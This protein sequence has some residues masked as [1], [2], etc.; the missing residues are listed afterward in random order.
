MRRV[1]AIVLLTGLLLIGPAL[2]SS[3]QAEGG[4]RPCVY[5][6]VDTYWVKQCSPFVFTEMQCYRVWGWDWPYEE[7]IVCHPTEV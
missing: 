2:A 6:A 3:A 1:L 5:V 7:V 4:V